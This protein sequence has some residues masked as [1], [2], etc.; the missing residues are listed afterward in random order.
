MSFNKKMVRNIIISTS[1]I[2]ALLVV[3]LVVYRWEPQTDNTLKQLEYVV[4]E[5]VSDINSIH[6]KNLEAEYDIV[7]NHDSKGIKYLISGLDEKKTDQIKAEDTVLSLICIQEVENINKTNPDLSDFGFN[8]PSCSY[9]IEKT[10]KET[11][12]ILIGDKIPSGEAYYCM[13]KGSGN[14][15]IINPYSVYA[16]I[17]QPKHYYLADVIEIENLKEIKEVSVSKNDKRIVSFSK[18]KDSQKLTDSDWSVV[19]PWKELGETEKINELIGMFSRIDTLEDIQKTDVAF[20]YSVKIVT[21]KKTYEFK[22]GQKSGDSV[23]LSFENKVYTVDE[24]IR[25]VLE[26]INPDDYAVKFVNLVHLDDIEKVTITTEQEDSY[27]LKIDKGTY[28]ANGNKIKEEDFK[29]IYTDITGLMYT[30]HV[31]AAKQK[32][33]YMNIIYNYKNGKTER[34]DFYEYDERTFI[35]V[36]TNGAD[37]IVLKSEINKIFKSIKQSNVK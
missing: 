12:T 34:I 2:V 14:I 22:I 30:Q 23:Y 33:P 29:K 35:A 3:Y 13:V 16:I 32:A 37:V 10:N 36:R 18:N 1:V 21:D 7:L 4:Y 8:S 6:I 28:F 11:I 25:A 26:N 15:H 20:D 9:T 27:E 17:L 5:D 19:Y 31:T 24:K